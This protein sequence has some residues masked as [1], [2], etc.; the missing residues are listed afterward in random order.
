M[1]QQE[2]CNFK[3]LRYILGKDCISYFIA[4][5]DVELWGDFGFLKIGLSFKMDDLWQACFSRTVYIYK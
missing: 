1:Y 4:I 2:S 3:K 5:I